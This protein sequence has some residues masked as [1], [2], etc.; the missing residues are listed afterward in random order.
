MKGV[1][2]AA[3]ARPAR[4]W[5]ANAAKR[6]DVMGSRWC[7]RVWSTRTSATWREKTTQRASRL[8]RAL[9]G[10][11]ALASAAAGAVAGIEG[12]RQQR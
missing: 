4:M 10:W 2:L 7:S 6:Q 8:R 12:G 5:R 9:A 1:A 3:K 11:V